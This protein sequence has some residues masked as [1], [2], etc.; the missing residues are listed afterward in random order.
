MLLSCLSP[1]LP[2]SPLRKKNSD[3]YRWSYP[4]HGGT[5]SG[6]KNKLLYFLFGY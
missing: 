1:F 6:D 3:Q 4:T 2:T 5:I